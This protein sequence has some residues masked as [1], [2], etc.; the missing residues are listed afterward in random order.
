[1]LERG[2]DMMLRVQ[3]LATFTAASEKQRYDG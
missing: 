3:I 2:M 1:V